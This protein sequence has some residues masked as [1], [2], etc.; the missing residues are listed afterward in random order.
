MSKS[1]P[2]TNANILSAKI[3]VT[4]DQH[5]ILIIGGKTSGGSAADGALIEDLLTEKDFNDNFGENSQIA[6]AGRAIVKKLELSR[7]RPKLAAISKD[8]NGAGVAATGIV[9]FAGTATAAGTLTIFI[10]NTDDGKYEIAVASG[11]TATVIGD[12]LV[13]AIT[14]NA[15][16]V[17]TA[18][19][20]GGSVALTATNDGTQ[21]NTIG[22]KQKGAVAGVTITTA[23]KLTGGATDP[24]LTTLFDPIADI[25]FQSIVYPAEWGISTL[26]NFLEPRFNVDNDVLD[27][28]GFVSVTDTFANLNTQVDA[29]NQRTLVHLPNKLVDDSD[30]RGGAIFESPITIAAEMA[31]IRGLRLTVGANISSFTI[32]ESRGGFFMAAVPYHTT[33]F[34]NLPVIETGR[35]FTEVEIKELIDSGGTLLVNNSASTNIILRSAKTTFKTNAQGQIDKTFKFLNFVD[36]LSLVREYIFDNAKADFAQNSLT[37]SEQIIRQSTI[38]AQIIIGIFTGYYLTLSGFGGDNSF[39]LLRAGQTEKIAFKNAVEES[40]KITLVD[41]KI[42]ITNLIAEILT[43][44]REINIDIIPTFN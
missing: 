12:A 18:I 33:P 6:K 38:N 9:L 40:L 27:G 4:P 32:K 29:L 7:N 30:Y 3:P 16:S 22:I 31:A 14:A 13:T 17:V 36:T 39:A 24:V 42:D 25:R 28:V 19:N 15:K 41:G 23:A 1:D 5:S 2:I 21:G 44:V 43:Q 26:T 34:A 11:D 35:G 37:D 20:T 8:D 10:D